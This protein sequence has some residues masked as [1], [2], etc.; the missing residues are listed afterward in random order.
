M[1]V[2]YINIVSWNLDFWRKTCNDPESKFYK[3]D[4]IR[5]IWKDHVYYNLFQLD[6]DFLLLQE[7][8]PYYFC[9]INDYRNLDTNPLSIY[10]FSADQKNIYYHELYQE[11][12][13]EL[14]DLTKTSILWGSAIIANTK[15]EFIQNY[16]D[17]PLYNEFKYYGNK[18]LMCYKFKLP[19]NK[20]ITIINH[21]KKNEFYKGY[22][23]DDNFINLLKKLIDK[24]DSDFIFFAGDFNTSSKDRKNRHIFNE[25]KDLGFINETERIGSTMINYDYQNDYVFVNNELSKYIVNIQKFSQWNISDHYGISCTIKL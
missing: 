15:Y 24:F 14:G 13:S 2:D 19:N 7:I 5:N 10:E 9:N 16:N 18:S 25:I 22:D 21:Y 3:S 11:L 1:S 12:A 6:A 4:R 23:Y 20:T 17:Q 8:N